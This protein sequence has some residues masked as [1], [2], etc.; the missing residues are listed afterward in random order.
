MDNPVPRQRSRTCDSHALNAL[1]R[2]DLEVHSDIPAL[3]GMGAEYR[4]LEAVRSSLR[5]HLRAMTILYS[6][7]TK[8]GTNILQNTAILPTNKAPLRK[9]IES[10]PP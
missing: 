2:S 4:I 3:V 10:I 6:K 5:L 1:E 9:Q 8:K 7:K